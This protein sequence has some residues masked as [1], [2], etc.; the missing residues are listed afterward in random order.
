MKIDIDIELLDKSILN[1]Y[2]T[3]SKNDITNA[4]IHGQR[5]VTNPS[6]NRLEI[7]TSQA[8]IDEIEKEKELLLDEIKSYKRSIDKIREETILEYKEL[9]K[10]RFLEKDERIHELKQ[11]NQL[12]IEDKQSL[13]SEMNERISDMKKLQQNLEEKNQLFKA[14]YDKLL[15]EK[16]ELE[17]I[18]NNSYKK[19]EYAENKLEQMLK[20]NVSIDFNVENVGSKEAHSTDIHLKTKENN[21]VI[22]VESKFYSTSSK[23]IIT[24]EVTKFNNDIDSCKSKMNVISA[25]FVSISCDIPNIT[26]DFECRI[27]KGI[28][29]YYFANMTAEKYK[30]LYVILGIENRI[31]KERILSE[32]SESMNRFLMR[33][34][35]EITTNYRKIEDLNPGYNEIRKELDKQ[36]KKYNKAIH[37]IMDGIKSVSDNFTKLAD[38]DSINI[39]DISYLLNIESPHSLN[40]NEWDSYKGELI[41]LRVENQ[42]LIDKNHE[43][44]SLR[45]KINSKD[46]CIK[47]LEAKVEAKVEKTNKSKSKSKSNTKK[48]S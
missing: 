19:G 32:G 43:L 3:A 44:H 42:D 47:Q 31:Y 25:I 13:I 37:K 18:M 1:W 6:F 38:I 11:Q 12:N 10:D 48:N 41:K 14:D 5:I 16:A 26:N 8:K 4:L 17:S 22:L 30:L 34:F 2:E 23:N 7:D 35:M 15:L 45:E 46:E 21:G 24:K 20:E 28:R 27:E 40:L 9:N 39:L 29:C 36:E 33:N